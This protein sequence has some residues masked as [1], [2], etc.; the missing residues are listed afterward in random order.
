MSPAISTALH[1]LPGGWF[2]WG[3]V[4]LLIISYLAY[5]VILFFLQRKLMY[6]GTMLT[7]PASPSGLAR[8]ARPVSLGLPGGPVTALY[9]PPPSG[10]SMHAAVI[11]CH[12]NYEL[13]VD[14]NPRFDEFRRMGMAVMILEYPGF[15]GSPG[16]PTEQS[17]IAAAVAAYDALVRMPGV[18][19]SRIVAFGRSLGGGVVCGLSRQRPLS[20]LILQS[21]FTSLTPFSA[22]Y[23]V[24]GFLVRDVYD[25]RAALASYPGPV[26]ILHGR[27][28]RVV[29]FSHGRKLAAAGRNVR[30]AE[31][32]AGHDDIIEMP[33]FW[34]EIEGFLLHEGIIDTPRGGA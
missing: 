13:A 25:N 10:A 2:P 19:P 23:L 21:T 6:P 5:C 29:P 22:R 30:F 12:G 17:T 34:A 9:L 27:Q 28:D 33:R 15:G 4:R 31:F 3:L 8:L 16:S 1:K 20:A 24:P 14:L 11:L 26:L 32:D 7:P 18:D